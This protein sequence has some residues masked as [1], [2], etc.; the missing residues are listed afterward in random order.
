MI[1]V[2]QRALA[3]GLKTID[4]ITCPVTVSMPSVH[5]LHCNKQVHRRI[6]KICLR[7]VRVVQKLEKD[8]SRKISVHFMAQCHH[9]QLDRENRP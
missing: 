5:F 4:E 7:G 8:Y 6:Q 1:G 9:G 3:L 2:D